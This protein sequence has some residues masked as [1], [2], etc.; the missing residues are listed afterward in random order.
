MAGL[1][2]VLATL[3]Q[4]SM[5]EVFELASG[6]SLARLPTS[7]TLAHG[8]TVSPDSTLQHGTPGAGGA[9]GLGVNGPGNPGEAGRAHLNY[10]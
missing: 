3:K 7:T 8:V 2:V 10:G 9:A 4:G 5:V 1:S 6:R